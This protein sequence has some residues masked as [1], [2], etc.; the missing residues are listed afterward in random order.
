M[1]I[2]FGAHRSDAPY[3]NAPSIGHWPRFIAALQD[4]VMQIGRMGFAW[5]ERDDHNIALEIDFYVLH[6]GNFRQHWSQFAHAL[7]AILAFS[8][9]FD[10]FQ[11]FVTGALREKRIGRIGISR[12]CRVHRVFGYLYI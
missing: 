12:S 11:N 7:I 6:A 1:G 10:R 2:N 9:D 5:V 4:C 8:G 3:Q